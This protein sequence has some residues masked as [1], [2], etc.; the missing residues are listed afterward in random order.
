MNEI[1]SDRI[2]VVGAGIAGLTSAATLRRLGWGVDLIERAPT[3]RDGGYKIDVRG[4]AV[5]VLDRLGLADTARARRTEVGAGVIVTADGGVVA[6]MGGDTFGGRTGHDIEIE[7]CDLVG[8]LAEVTGPVRHG[9]ELTGLTPTTDGV[10]ASYA[11]G[12]RATYR[13]VVGADGVGSTVRLDRAADGRHR[14]RRGSALDGLCHRRDRVGGCGRSGSGG[15]HLREPRRDRPRLCHRD[16]AQSLDN[17]TRPPSASC[18][19][20]SP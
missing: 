17:S 1:H 20:G 9:V 18:P 4:S 6:A 10:E 2:L 11:D 19:L 8:L 15:V 16:P 7:R 12:T 5:E 14:R 13:A 3:L